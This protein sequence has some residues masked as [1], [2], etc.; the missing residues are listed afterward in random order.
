MFAHLPDLG[1]G[2]DWAEVWKVRP[3]APLACDECRHPM[4]A[5]VFSSSGLRFFAHA[6]GAPKCALT[7]ESP[8]HHLL[9]LELAAAARQA[10]AH[11]ELEVRG[12]DGAWRADVL[13]SDPAGAWR[14]ALEA[15]LSPITPDDIAARTERMLQD[16]VSSV[17]FSDRMRAP[18]FGTVPWARVETGDGALAVREGLAKFSGRHWEAGPQGVPAAEFL[19]WVFAGRVLSHRRRAPVRSPLPAWGTV[20][21]APQYADA[22][23][24]YLDAEERRKRE[25]AERERAMLLR[26]REEQQLQMQ[27]EQERECQLVGV[28]AGDQ[29]EELAQQGGVCEDR[30][31]Q[32]AGGGLAGGRVGVVP[33]ARGQGAREPGV[34]VGLDVPA[35]AAG[36]FVAYGFVAFGRLGLV[37]GVEVPQHLEVVGAG[38]DPHGFAQLGLP[39]GGCRGVGGELGLDD[40]VDV[41][42]VDGARPGGAEQRGGALPL[43]ELRRAA[44]LVGQVQPRFL[45]GRRDGAGVHPLRSAPYGTAADAGRVDRLAR[46]SDARGGGGRRAARRVGQGLVIIGLGDRSGCSFVGE[47]GDGTSG[48]AHQHARLPQ[49]EGRYDPVVPVRAGCGL[50]TGADLLVARGQDH[51]K[52]FVRHPVGQEPHQGSRGLQ[53]G[54]DAPGA[55]LV[56][57]LA[58]QG[59][60]K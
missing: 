34:D 44:E 12:P 8:A 51:T 5:K 15:Q 39:S 56:D 46:R 25:Q 55:E 36:E 28:G 59:G 6:P 7:E 10:G 47:V 3:L 14:T 29:A 22:E 45:E 60:L 27:R 30:R 41:R 4:Y 9:K 13:A 54:G 18:W 26:R 52:L 21:T 33:E 16:G 53:P 1:C 32:K 24:A 17:W 2:R 31:G 49:G 19:R 23:T 50:Q 40:V 58:G 11:A 38:R 57:E 48:A 20:W 35:R 37:Q 42:V 43:R